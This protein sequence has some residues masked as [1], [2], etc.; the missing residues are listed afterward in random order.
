[1]ATTKQTISKLE[2]HERECA[3]R[4]EN[5]EKRLDKGDRKFDAMDTKFTRL[6]VGLYVLIA[7]AAGV[8]RFFS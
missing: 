1:M 3:I 4:Y 8:D 7:V 5:I 6:I 2:A